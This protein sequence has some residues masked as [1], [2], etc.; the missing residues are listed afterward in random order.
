PGRPVPATPRPVSLDATWVVSSN[1]CEWVRAPT[2]PLAPWGRG[3][4]GEGWLPVPLTPGPSPLGGE[5]GKMS[6]LLL[7]LVL[8]LERQRGQLVAA[9]HLDLQLGA[10]LVAVQRLLELLDADH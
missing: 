1:R 10:R 6:R 5:G 9:A 3:V 7:G 4:G 8:D 2:T